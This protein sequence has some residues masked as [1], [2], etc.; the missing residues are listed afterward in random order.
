[1][2]KIIAIITIGLFTISAMAQN[3]QRKHEFQIY[4][5]GGI[6]SLEYDLKYGDHKMGLGGLAGISYNYFFHYN[7]SIGIG[8]EFSLLQAKA[9]FKGSEYQYFTPIQAKPDG[10]E[11]NFEIHLTPDFH[12]KQTAYYVNIPLRLQFQTDVF[13]RNKFYAAIGA[14]VG[15][16]IIDA[17]SKFEGAYSTKGWEY[18]NGHRVTEHAFEG[19]KG[20]VTNQGVPGSEHE[21]QLADINIIGTLE[22]GMKWPVGQTGRNAWYT[23]LFVDYGFSDV[24]PE[25]KGIRVSYIDEMMKEVPVIETNWVDKVNTLTF[26]AKIGFAFGFGGTHIATT[27]P[28]FED[29]PYEGITADQ[30]D[31]ILGKNTGILVDAM[32]RNFNEL[33]DK[34]KKEE[35]ELFEPFPTDEFSI[36]QFDFD[37]TDVKT[38]YYPDIDRKIEV[39]KRYPEVRM[40][41][42]GHTDN[43]GSEQYNYELGMRRAQHVKDY[44]VHRGIAAD[45]L[46]VESKGETQPLVPNTTDA[47]RYKNRRV[48]FQLRK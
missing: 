20:F 17:K 24:R 18:R 11:T 12:E 19:I 45:R 44:M 42:I 39:L 21:Y 23:G 35:P 27:K 10:T 43:K 4:A 34:L 36:V 46:Y 13:K 40:T 8:A 30:L 15:I 47:N 1:M 3:E 28:L 6:S 41:L 32:D 48:E 16:P 33:F 2:K 38:A 9:E 22:L 37:K 14:K 5:G 26:G 29:K 7:W 31:Q 25:A